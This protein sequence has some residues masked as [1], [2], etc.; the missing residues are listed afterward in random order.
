MMEQRQL[1]WQFPGQIPVLHPPTQ[2]LRSDTDRAGG[3]G[4]TAL[5]QQRRNRLFPPAREFGAVA[6]DPRPPPFAQGHAPLL[7]CMGQAFGI[8]HGRD[9]IFYFD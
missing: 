1:G 5:R 3:F 7:S 8:L 2:G 6:R 9:K 4:D